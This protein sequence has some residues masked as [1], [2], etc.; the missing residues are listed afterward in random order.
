MGRRINHV[1]VGSGDEQV[2]AG[3]RDLWIMK[4]L[5]FMQKHISIFKN[6]LNPL[7]IFDFFLAR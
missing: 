7:I 5:A 3:K 6:S 2:R 4:K 1:C